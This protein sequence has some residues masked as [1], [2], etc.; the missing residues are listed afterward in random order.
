M[1]FKDIIAKHA[2]AQGI[3]WRGP[4]H[5]EKDARGSVG[6]Y[7]ITVCYDSDTTPKL[8]KAEDYIGKYH[9]HY[10]PAADTVDGRSVLPNI[11]NQDSIGA[12]LN[13]YH[14]LPGVREFN[15]DEINA[16]PNSMFYAADD[17]KRVRE[18]AKKI[19]HSNSISPL[20]MAIDKDGPYILE[21]A[22]RAG[23]LHMLGAKSFPAQVVLDKESLGQPATTE[24]SRSEDLEPVVKKPKKA[25]APIDKSV[26]VLRKPFKSEAQRKYFHWAAKQGKG[27]ITPEM[28]AKWEA[29]TSGKLPEKLDKGAKGDWQKEG[30]RLSHD[31]FAMDSGKGR[32]HHVSA[33]DKSGKLVGH[34]VFNAH[35]H[36]P[37]QLFIESSETHPSHQRK[38]LATAAYKLAEE[39]ANAKITPDVQTDD[40]KALWA[41]PNR[42]FGKSDDLAKGLKGDWQKEGYTFDHKAEP[43]FHHIT[44]R[45]A[46][47]DEVGDY[48]F[49]KWSKPKPGYK[50]L[51]SETHPDHQR[52]G[53][54]SEAYRMVQ[55]H[56]GLPVLPDAVQTED[57]KALW[58]GRSLSKSSAK[59]HISTVAV[60]DGSKL[61]MGKRR[62]NGKYTN[63]G[64]H[65]NDNEDPKDGAF[66]ELAEEA[67]ITP[68]NMKHLAS[69]D[70]TTPKGDQKTIHCYLAEHSGKTSSKG[71]P[72]KEVAEWEWIDTSKGLPDHVANNLHS[73]DN[74][75]LQALGL[76]KIDTSK[77]IPYLAGYSKSGKC[78]YIDKRLPKTM[79]LKDGRT[80]NIIKYLAV[81]EAVEKK[82]EDAKDYDYR[83]A[84]EQ[85][86]GDERKAVEADYIPWKEYQDYM[87]GEVKKLSKLDSEVPADIDL[88]PEEDYDDKEMIEKVKGLQKSWHVKIKGREHEGWHPVKN[89]R[90]LGPEKGNN[91]ELKSGEKV[92]QSKLAEVSM[93]KPKEGLAKAAEPGE[94][95]TME[96]I[97]KS[98]ARIKYLLE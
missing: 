52:K 7:P 82:L 80:V 98:L 24:L 28:A 91:Y 67:G 73:P 3:D 35:N 27:G 96:A 74:A 90:D 49:T 34:Y 25:L 9:A 5:L 18:L 93:D 95:K 31:N 61:L 29:H 43:D 53:L 26:E 70:V 92:H 59:R 8:S 45:N 55:A 1:N 17:H 72:D 63:P 84:H 11:D 20:I 77:E 30:Y 86:T 42:S 62:D 16:H 48:R 33:H 88:K 21:G 66:R 56:T 47:G 37:G 83:Y 97:K 60:M 32:E 81:H 41:N 50:V 15:M 76:Q 4:D 94:A 46:A 79:T 87:L 89:V 39:K 64:G 38:G 14:V 36:K 71:D 19:K 22:H 40:A 12:S 85:A 69:T 51:W 78:V 68:D 6:T 10:K 23:A 44:A 75:L 58:A 65:L 13:D 54:A 57:A 2:L